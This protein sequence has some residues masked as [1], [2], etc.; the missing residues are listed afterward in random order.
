M[1]SWR[2]WTALM[3]AACLTGLATGT[4]TFSVQRWDPCRCAA[5]PAAR[6]GLAEL[7]GGSG[8]C[9]AISA[10]AMVLRRSRL[11]IG[12]I[13]LVDFLLLFRRRVRARDVEGPVLHEIVIGVAA[14]GLAAAGEF[15]VAFG[16]RC[17]LLFLR[18]R[19]LGHVGAC[20]EIGRRATPP[21][22]I[23][24]TGASTTRPPMAATTNANVREAI[25]DD[26]LQPNSWEL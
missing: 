17:R 24:R 20:L 10:A 13:L 23:A 6:P 2:S 1:Y 11:E 8:C 16:E 25:T 15:R 5:R 4:G 9:L 7:G 19:L 22:R 18:L 14:A 21:L 26:I 3:R 12:G